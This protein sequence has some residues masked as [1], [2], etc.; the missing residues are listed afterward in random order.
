MVK[1]G[2]QTFLYYHVYLLWNITFTE[3]L[4]TTLKLVN[5][6]LRGKNQSYELSKKI[7]F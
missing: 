5:S 4:R 2:R 1:I 6:H 7:K 3:M